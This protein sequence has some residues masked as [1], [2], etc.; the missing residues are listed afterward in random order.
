MLKNTN[1]VANIDE[2]FCSKCGEKISTNR[3][4]YLCVEPS[5]SAWQIAYEFLIYEHDP[6]SEPVKFD[7]N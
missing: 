7:N 4:N 5:K 1:G 6:A 3:E 2:K